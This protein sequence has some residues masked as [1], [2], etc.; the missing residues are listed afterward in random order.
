MKA[1]NSRGFQ[2]F[3]E[4]FEVNK[5][6]VGLETEI[7]KHELAVKQLR[8]LI[9]ELA[10]DKRKNIQHIVGGNLVM[11]LT[12]QAAIKILQERKE[13]IEIGLK[14]MNEQYKQR[15]DTMDGLM[16]KIYRITRSHV[17]KDVREEIEKE[18]NG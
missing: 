12:G 13:Q 4:I 11:E 6:L 7:G 17:D 18:L 5:Q 3:M 14:S 2:P 1:F 16:I 15:Q 8:D 9:K 10:R